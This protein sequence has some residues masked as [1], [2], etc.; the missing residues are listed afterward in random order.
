M[1]FREINTRKHKLTRSCQSSFLGDQQ[2]PHNVT[3]LLDQF[4]AELQIYY[5]NLSKS[6][7]YIVYAQLDKNQLLKLRQFFPH[8][9]I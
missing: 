8:I 1:N 7:F 4:V 5:Y 9:V 2:G 3:V 6:S